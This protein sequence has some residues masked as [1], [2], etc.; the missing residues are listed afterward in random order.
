MIWVFTHIFL[1][2]SIYTHNYVKFILRNFPAEDHVFWTVKPDI[3]HDLSNA[4][5][6]KIDPE[7]LIDTFRLYRF[8]RNSR[9]VIIHSLFYTKFYPVLFVQRSLL[10]KAVWIIWGADLYSYLNSHIINKPKKFKLKVKAYMYK[11][12]VQ[13]L[14]WIGSLVKGDYDRL[15]EHIDTK[16]E[17]RHLFYPNPVDFD[18]LDKILENNSGRS[19]S[20]IVLLNHSS[21]ADGFHIEALNFL[22]NYVTHNTKIICPL[23]YGNKDY[24]QYVIECGQEMY[25]ERFVPLT[26]FLNPQEYGKLLNSVDVAVFNHSYQAGLGNIL[27]L[28]Y[29][30]KKVYIR[31]ETSPW[32]MLIDLGVKVFDTNC[33]TGGRETDFWYMS[34]EDRENNR[35]IIRKEFSEEK[36]AQ[37]WRSFFEEGD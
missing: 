33:L 15:A 34:E 1:T 4:Q 2:D 8:A 12:I 18:L 37:L 31:S 29:L 35:R 7:D 9:K 11:K 22:R 25:G 21:R 36:C 26:E 19:E 13:N 16:A 28:L 10:R 23:S 5:I 27:A 24:A 20:K 14:R 3:Y 17:W 6:K 32:K 30:G